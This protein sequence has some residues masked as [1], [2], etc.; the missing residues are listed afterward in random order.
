MR[1]CT[2]IGPLAGIDFTAHAALVRIPAQ[3]IAEFGVAAGRDAVEH[4]RTVHADIGE[5]PFG[6]VRI[7]DREQGQ[8]EV[9]LRVEVGVGYQI[10]PGDIAL[11]GRVRRAQHVLVGQHVEHLL[12]IE[13]RAIDV[14]GNGEERFLAQQVARLGNAARRFQR[15]GLGRIRDARAICAAVAQGFLDQIAQVRMVDDDVRDAGAHQVQ[16]MPDDQR[17]A[18]HFQ[19]RFGAGIGKRTHPFTAAC[20]KDHGFHGVLVF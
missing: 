4:F 19:Q 10:G 3:Q 7:V 16:H 8:A 1:W 2:H 11:V 6:V 18:A 17:T 9:A 20:G 12:E 15:R 5:G 14:A 13:I